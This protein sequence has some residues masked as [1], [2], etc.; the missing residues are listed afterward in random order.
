M[1]KRPHLTL[2]A[3]QAAEDSGQE[4]MFGGCK[5]VAIVLG[6]GPMSILTCKS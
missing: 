3:P 4:R 2:P 5:R 1:H 6:Y